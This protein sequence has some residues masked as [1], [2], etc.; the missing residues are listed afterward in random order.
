MITKE[1]SLGDD[2][3]PKALSDVY[4]YN[5]FSITAKRE[6]TGEA[7][8]ASGEPKGEEVTIPAGTVLNAVST[9]E[10]EYVILQ[11][12]DTGELV[13]LKVSGDW[14]NWPHTIDG[15]DI[16]ELFDGLIFAG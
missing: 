16:E 15:T 12:A 4:S 8:T 11:S 6:L 10:K 7:V 3:M 14:G 5:D 13:R 2:G 1:Y 9:D